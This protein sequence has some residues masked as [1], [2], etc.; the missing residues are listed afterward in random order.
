MLHSPWMCNS[1]TGFN[2]DNGNVR[3]QR[4][5]QTAIC[6]QMRKF[7]TAHNHVRTREG[8]IIIELEPNCSQ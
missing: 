6:V 2:C 7:P 4:G 1:P 3:I 5:V 8:Y